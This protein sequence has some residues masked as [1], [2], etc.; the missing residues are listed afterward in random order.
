MTTRRR[1][2]SAALLEL[3]WSGK[4]KEDGGGGESEERGSLIFMKLK[5][6]LQRRAVAVKRTEFLFHSLTLSQDHIEGLSSYVIRDHLTSTDR[7]RTP[8]ID[9]TLCA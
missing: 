4:L 8:E 7:L 1:V 6:R 2:R 5:C 9:T 3:G